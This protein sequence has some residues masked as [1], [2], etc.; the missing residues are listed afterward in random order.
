MKLAGLRTDRSVVSCF[1]FALIV[2]ALTVFSDTAPSAAASKMKQKTFASPEEAVKT[3]IDAMKKDNKKELSA[4][5]GPRA[6]SQLSSGDDVSDKADRERFVKAYEEKNSLEKKDDSKAILLVGIEDWPMPIPLVK[7]GA[8][9]YFDTMAGKEEMLNRRVGRNELRVIDAVQAYVGAQREYAG[10][11]W[12]GDGIYPYAQKFVSSPGKKDGLYWEAKTGE[13]ESPSGPFAAAAARE[14]YATKAK[15]GK[16]SPFH[17]YYFRILKTQG[18]HAPGG[19]YDYVVK[20]KMILGFGLVAYPAKYG[21][22]GIMTFIVNQEGVVY[23]KD[24]GKDTAKVAAAI[25]KYDPDNTWKKA[26]QTGTK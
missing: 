7:K 1:I 5:F 15:A 24:L 21:S 12:D 13:A 25:R 9:W 8:G 18:S 10:R 4:I 11:D 19:A 17:G 22:S 3:F 16:P 23:E 14:G 6:L 20:G 2:I 26:E